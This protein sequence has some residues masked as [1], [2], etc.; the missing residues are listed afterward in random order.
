MSDDR[1]PPGVRPDAG[2]PLLG[3]TVLAVEDSRFA[4]EALRLLCLRSG[5]RLRRA[6]SLRAARQ[7]LRAYRPGAA[8]V[9]LGLPDGRG[10]ALIAELRLRGPRVPVVL[11]CSGDDGARAR[12]MRAGADGFLD[13]PVT[14]LASFQRAILSGLDASG[15]ATQAAA[16]DDIVRPDRLALRDDLVRAAL[17]L[18]SRPDAAALDY[19]AQFLRGLGRDSRDPRLE[20]AAGWIAARDARALS[21]ASRLV[22]ARIRAVDRV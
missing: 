13:K 17:M 10:E 9:D 20:E 14:S 21:R 18:S 8:I 6:D 2:R 4:C 12:A 7:H 5:A 19:A 16:H 3:L 1:S 11:G 22:Q 15:R